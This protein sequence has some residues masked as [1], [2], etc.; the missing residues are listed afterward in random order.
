[1]L[2]DLGFVETEK[3]GVESSL[4]AVR[5]RENLNIVSKPE[6]PTLYHERIHIEQRSCGSV[7]WKECKC[8]TALMIR[9]G[10]DAGQFF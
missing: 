3:Y 7:N 1:M 5:R 6:H 10:D 2:K 4:N 9:R 8:V